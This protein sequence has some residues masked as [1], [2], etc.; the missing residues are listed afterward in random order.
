MAR[1]RADSG[2]RRSKHLTRT[3]VLSARVFSALC[4]PPPAFSL[5]GLALLSFSRSARRLLVFVRFCCC[6]GSGSAPT[7]LVLGTSHMQFSC[8]LANCTA[9]HRGPFC[10]CP[11]RLR[12]RREGSLSLSLWHCF[13]CMCTCRYIYTHMHACMSVTMYVCMYVCMYVY[14]Y[15]HI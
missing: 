12:G 2:P 4:T 9:I 13:G 15:I 7:L 5:T 6:G 8:A 1:P 3:H 11:W 10:C 14:I